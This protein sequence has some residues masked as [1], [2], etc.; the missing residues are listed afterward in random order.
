MVGEW[1]VFA[2]QDGLN[3]YLTLADHQRGRRGHLAQVQ[4]VCG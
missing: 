1:I 2:K 4:S 3:Y